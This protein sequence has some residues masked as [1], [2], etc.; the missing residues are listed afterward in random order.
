MMV[1]AVDAQRA[2]EAGVFAATEL[3]QTRRRECLHCHHTLDTGEWF[4]ILP[5]N[6]RAMRLE[7]VALR[8]TT[9][10][11]STSNGSMKPARPLSDLAGATR[12]SWVR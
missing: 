6:P 3:A 1:A 5:K 9:C 12:I 8:L 7:R 11:L 4:V 2:D 10:D